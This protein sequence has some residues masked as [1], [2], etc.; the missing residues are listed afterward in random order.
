MSAGRIYW[1]GAAVVAAAATATVLAT[2][3]LDRRSVIFGVSSAFALQLPLGLW[4]VHRIGSPQLLAVWGIGML[5]RFTALAL[6]GL[7]VV[8]AFGL[9]VSPALISLAGTMVAL[10]AVESV[11]SMRHQPQGMV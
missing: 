10:L 11:A 6:F 7:I 9:A 5:S 4:L 1:V 3:S 2:N 8:P